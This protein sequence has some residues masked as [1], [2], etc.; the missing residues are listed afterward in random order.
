MQ[1]C[2]TPNEDPKE[3]KMSNRN[4]LEQDNSNSE[5][6]VKS[7]RLKKLHSLFDLHRSSKKQKEKIEF[8]H[9]KFQNM[10]PNASEKTKTDYEYFGIFKDVIAETFH[11]KMSAK[12][13]MMSEA[14]KKISNEIDVIS[15]LKKLQDVEKLKRIVP[16]EKQLCLFNFIAKPMI[17]HNFEQENFTL[18]TNIE[19]MNSQ[20]IGNSSP[21]VND[22]QDS[23]KI[24]KIYHANLK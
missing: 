19:R 12:E 8:G 17:Y 21:S 7:T 11:F 3:D 16:N 15:I 14:Q 5:K 24:L 18:N 10:G 13:K 2:D 4:E 23:Q 1:K 22:M 6:V 9:Q 20:Q